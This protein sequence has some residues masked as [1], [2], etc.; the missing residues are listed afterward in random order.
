VSKPDEDPTLFR[1]TELKG[2]Y[3]PA[4][5]FETQQVFVTSKDGTEVPMFIISKKGAV[6]DGNNLTLLYGYGGTPLLDCAVA[7]VRVVVT[8][9]SYPK[10][11]VSGLHGL[12][13]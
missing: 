9:T 1:K 12:P 13:E 2:G 10:E 3:S 4:D 7:Q 11:L 6:L 5:D 8:W